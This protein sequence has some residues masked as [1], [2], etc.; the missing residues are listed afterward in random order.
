MA[1]N[2]G[3][4]WRLVSVAEWPET[5]AGTESETEAELESEAE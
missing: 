2:L 3:A 5:G 4:F 1:A